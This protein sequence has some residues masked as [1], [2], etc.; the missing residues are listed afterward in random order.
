M[1]KNRLLRPGIF[2]IGNLISP[3]HTRYHARVLGDLED[4]MC[5]EF[6]LDLL[7]QGFLLIGG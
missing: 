2:L 4:S 3:L 6:D 1:G 5:V 7:P